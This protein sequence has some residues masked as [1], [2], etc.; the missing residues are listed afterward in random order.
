MVLSKFD[1]TDR[2]AIVTGAGKGIGRGIAL[3]LAQAGAH[4]VVA[5]R[6][7]ADL[8]NIAGEIRAVGRRALAVPT[9]VRDSGQIANMVERTLTEFGKI[10]I[11]VNSAGGFSIR[12]VLQ[13]P[14]E[15]WDAII[16]KN[17]RSVFLC[18][19]AAG[20]VMVEQR[21]GSIINISS[22]GAGFPDPEA[23]HYGAAKAAINSLTQSL[24]VE[25]GQY[26][27]RVNT[28][29]PGLVQ[30]PGADYEHLGGPEMVRVR[31]KA[32]AL[33]R[34]GTPED[35]VGAAIFL[36][37]D[38]SEYVTGANILVHGGYLPFHERLLMEGS[39]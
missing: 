15:L 17:L 16:G 23:A 37:S 33:R 9:D 32:I 22:A 26:G 3:G 14:E 28:L 20:A 18:C 29:S 38:A 12:P 8:E 27:V 36:A 6:T 21:R 2:V 7:A 25:W 34:V 1:L 30:T 4:V 24:A 35:L 13:M 19:K 39:S 10:D 31:I 11:L 5:A